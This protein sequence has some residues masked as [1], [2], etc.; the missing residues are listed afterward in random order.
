MIYLNSRVRCC[1]SLRRPDSFNIFSKV[2]SEHAIKYEGLRKHY[3]MVFYQKWNSNRE[4]FKDLEEFT[5]DK[6]KGK[7]LE[8]CLE[9][10]EW[11]VAQNGVKVPQ[12]IV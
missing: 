6:Q 3:D 10:V 7:I 8:R 9:L 5:D 2:S 12:L 4:Y 11:L 1:D